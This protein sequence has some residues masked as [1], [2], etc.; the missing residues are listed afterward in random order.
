M[1]LK[2]PTALMIGRYQPFHD[3]HKALFLESLKRV[4]QV[5]I[6]VRDTGGLNTSNPFHMEDVIR[7][8]EEALKDYS[9]QFIVIPAPNITA[10]YY[11]RD[12]GYSVEKIDLPPEVEAISATNIRKEMGI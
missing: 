9:G 1:D 12:V 4:G 3:G 11:G 10:V 8:I 6:M 2:K 7:R 5:C